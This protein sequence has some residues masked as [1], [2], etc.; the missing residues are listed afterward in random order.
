MAY[1]RASDIARY[2]LWYCTHK[3]DPI[4][5]MKLQKILFFVWR[6]Y[7]KRTGKKLFLEYICAWKSGPVVP[8]VFHEYGAYAG[9]AIP[10]T[11]KVHVDDET[12]LNMIIENYRQIPTWKLIEM[13]LK[14][15]GPW[16]RTY[17]NGEGLS[18][19]IPFANIINC[20]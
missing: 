8:D 11:E 14:D 13:S 18:K 5:N 20:G 10:I 6:D 17:R 12:I 7:Q 4:N 15:N 1:Q 2:V 19:V 16:A 9:L 3:N